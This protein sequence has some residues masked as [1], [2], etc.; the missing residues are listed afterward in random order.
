MEY[1]LEEVERDC[2]GFKKWGRNK[3]RKS[4]LASRSPRTY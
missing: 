3:H 2:I 1:E 4:K